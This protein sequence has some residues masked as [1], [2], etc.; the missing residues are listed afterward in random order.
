MS[1]FFFFFKQQT[2]K[3]TLKTQDLEH[4]CFRGTKTERSE[5][6]SD[7]TILD[8]LQCNV[9]C[10]TYVSPLILF[11]LYTTRLTKSLHPVSPFR[12]YILSHAECGSLCVC[13][14]L[15][16]LGREDGWGRKH[17]LQ[18]GLLRLALCPTSDTLLIYS[19]AYNCRLAK[20]QFTVDVKTQFY[21]HYGTSI[22][23]LD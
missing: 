21:T 17:K 11:R 19:E 15:C 13:V 7:A 1:F 14:W 23:I 9:L 12:A 6:G 18:A 10:F 5:W 22:S 20:P 16:I 3:L 4:T 2:T 8:I